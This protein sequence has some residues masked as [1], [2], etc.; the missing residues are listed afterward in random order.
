MPSRP[1]T[2][3]II[4]FWLATTGYMFY[5]EVLRW[6]LAD[7]PPPIAFELADEVGS[8]LVNWK[9]SQKAEP[10]GRATSQVHRRPDRTFQLVS[11]FT[12][13][14]LSIANQLDVRKITVVDR[15]T[16]EGELRGL[17]V[18]IKAWPRE[19]NLVHDLLPEL[20]GEIRGRV[21]DGHLRVK[22]FLNDQEL[23]LFTPAPVP[24][25]KDRNVLNPMRLQNKM[26]GLRVGQRWRVPGMDPLAAVIPDVGLS[27]P[28]LEA[29]VFADER[30]WNGET[31]ACYRIDVNEPGKKVTGRTWVRRKD[32][33]VLHL[34][35]ELHGTGMA[36]EREPA[37]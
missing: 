17:A 26:P 32:A 34:E 8:Q 2:W 1:L 33:L 23:T 37:K 5:R 29:E 3:A 28:K 19:K 12:F 7:A 31:F 14:R 11:E 22:F 18:K 35:M 36:V 16:P 30:A 9:V 24:V 10:I 21:E 4:V 6:A 13:D 27:V 20:T 25:P 15:V